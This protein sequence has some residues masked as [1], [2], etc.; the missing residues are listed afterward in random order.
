MYS[1]DSS[2]AEKPPVLA[3]VV[4]YRR[5]PGIESADVEARYSSDSIE[6]EVDCTIP[7]TST[8]TVLLR[9]SNERYRYLYKRTTA[10][11]WGRERLLLRT[12]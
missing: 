2:H 11:H 4:Q 10:K 8:S 12:L 9:E 1:L 5:T 3:P 6:Y 7:G